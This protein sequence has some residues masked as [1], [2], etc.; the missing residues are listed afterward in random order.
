MEFE[1]DSNT[2]IRTLTAFVRTKQNDRV[3]DALFAAAAGEQQRFG[4]C[5]IAIRANTLSETGELLSPK[6]TA[7]WEVSRR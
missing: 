2:Q 6:S 4:L 7:R 1:G 5:R 3:P